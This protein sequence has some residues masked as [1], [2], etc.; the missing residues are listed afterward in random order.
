L[1]TQLCGFVRSEKSLRK[2]IRR[3]RPITL[4]SDFLFD[5]LL[6]IF[7]MDQEDLIEGEQD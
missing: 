7:K 2:L 1:P 6:L 5:K 4:P 3:L